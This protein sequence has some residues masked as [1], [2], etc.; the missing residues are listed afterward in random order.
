MAM[1]KAFQTKR[2]I[3]L[4][5]QQI[6]RKIANYLHR[7]SS[8]FNRR[9]GQR[10]AIYANDWIGIQ[11]NLQGVYEA[12]LL[13]IIFSFLAPLKDEFRKGLALDIGANIGNHSVFF[14]PRFSKVFSFE[15]NQATFK[16]LEFNTSFSA[17]VTPYPFGF[18][19]T[20][21]LVDFFEDRENYGGSSISDATKQ[22]D[23]P[24]TRVEVKELDSCGLPLEGLRFI[25]LDVEGHEASVLQ[26]GTEI[27]KKHRPIIMFEQLKGEFRGR[28][29]ESLDLLNSLGYEVFWHQLE[30]S[31]G[32]WLWRRLFNLIEVFFGKELTESICY[33]PDVPV[34]NHDALI[35]IHAMECK[36]LGLP[37]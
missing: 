12:E 19:N 2:T 20:S 27:I 31:R 37:Y 17:N 1:H 30:Q 13:E 28:T 23:L 11:V 29:T 32:P 14:S 24:P 33:G 3:S 18:S 26:G 9:R 10:L 36:R 22:S 15:P 5:K 16:L 34:R 4:V 35:A 25:K 21:G 7:Q 8:Q 6:D